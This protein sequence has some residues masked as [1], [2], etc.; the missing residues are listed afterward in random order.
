MHDHSGEVLGMAVDPN[1][2][3][4]V[5]GSA[6]LSGASVD[7]EHRVR[8]GAGAHAHADP[9]LAAGPVDNELA[10]THPVGVVEETTQDLWGSIPSALNPRASTTSAWSCVPGC[11]SCPAL[12][13]VM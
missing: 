5:E 12:A 8:R 11:S 4:H 13:R 3:A 10:P 9:A 2:G 6:V 1:Q 7:I